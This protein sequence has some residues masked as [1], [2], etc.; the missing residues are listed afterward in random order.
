MNTRKK[1]KRTLRAGHPG[2]LSNL[3]VLGD[4]T[5][6]SHAATV[7][8]QTKKYFWALKCGGR[9]SELGKLGEAMWWREIKRTLY[10]IFDY[11][12]SPSPGSPSCPHHWHLQTHLRAFHQT[13]LKAFHHNHPTH[14]P[15]TNLN[16][17]VVNKPAIFICNFFLQPP[18]I[19]ALTCNSFF[20]IVSPFLLSFFYSWSFLLV[21][22]QGLLFSGDATNDALK[23]LWPTA[24]S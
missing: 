4:K 3:Q 2:V 9:L 17:L 15:L 13:H 23:M 22:L 20:S 21:S 6:V 10:Y 16:L 14:F 5:R 12:I 8:V 24:S 18:K 11:Q 19:H 7:R 1:W